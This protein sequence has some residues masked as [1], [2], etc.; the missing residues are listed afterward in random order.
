MSEKSLRNQVDEP[1]KIHAATDQTAAP[2]PLCKHTVSYFFLA[3]RHMCCKKRVRRQWTE[4]KTAAYVP[5]VSLHRL[6]A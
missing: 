4:P 1:E 2:T 5:Q 6:G 3:R